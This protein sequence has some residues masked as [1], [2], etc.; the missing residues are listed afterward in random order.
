MPTSSAQPPIRASIEQLWPAEVNASVSVPQPAAADS[1][2]K[3]SMPAGEK[4]IT[5][6]EFAGLSQLEKRK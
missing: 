3:I 6:L 2:A 5:L 1:S 4:A